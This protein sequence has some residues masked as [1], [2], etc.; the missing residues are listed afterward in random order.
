MEMFILSYANVL[1]IYPKL[2]LQVGSTFWLRT[3][4]LNQY[5]ILRYCSSN[6]CKWKYLYGDLPFFKIQV[7][8]FMAQ[9][10]SFGAKI[11]PKCILRLRNL[12]PFWVLRHSFLSLTDCWW[13]Y[14][15]QLKINSGVLCLPSS[16]ANVKSFLYLLY[17]LIKLYYTKALSYQAS[18][19]APDWILLLRGPRIPAS[20]FNITLSLSQLFSERLFSSLF[21]IIRPLENL[22]FLSN[23]VSH[24]QLVL[25]PY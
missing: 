5:V 24:T 25:F 23:A 17:T 21:K 13:P 12:V 3:F 14:N 9:A 4:L 18:S 15:I 8:H 2:C 6:L 20:R 7:N 22:G 1:C 16:D 11:I 10:E 19:L